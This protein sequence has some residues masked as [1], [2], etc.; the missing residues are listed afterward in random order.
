MQSPAK[1]KLLGNAE[2]SH[3]S[4][5]VRLSRSVDPS[6]KRFPV[7]DP[8]ITTL[9]QARQ[10]AHRLSVEALDERLKLA[11]KSTGDTCNSDTCKAWF[12]SWCKEREKR[13]TVTTA[14]HDRGRLSEHVLPIL[15]AWRMATV[16]REKIEEV[17]E[18]LD[19]K[20]KRG[21]ISWK[22]AATTWGVVSKGFKDAAGG[23][24]KTLRVRDDNPAIG[25]A[26]PDRGGEKSKA[27]LYPSEFWK[28]I[29]SRALTH[30]EGLPMHVAANVANAS[31]RWLRSFVLAAYLGTRAGEL[32]ALDWQD[33]DLEH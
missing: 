6:R 18:H 4:F 20:V 19:D 33:I 16:P 11:P 21:V 10:L 3:G 9:E 7:E 27:F 1:N 8:R 22:T 5:F 28:L 12:E 24:V 17:V 15:G 2:F 32:A 30:G 23:K 31:R 25:V 29:T 13:G 26:P 14:R